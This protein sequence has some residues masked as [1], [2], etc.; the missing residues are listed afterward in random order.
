M[1]TERQYLEDTYQFSC[2]AKIQATHQDSEGSYMLLDKTIFYPQGG[3]QPSDQGTIIAGGLIIPIQKVKHVENEIKHYTDR[4]Y[5]HLVGQNVECAISKETRLL[6]SKLHTAGHLISHI[7]EKLHPNWSAQKGHHFPKEC[8]IEFIS[9]AE[10][11][12]ACAF[13]EINQ[14]IKQCIYKNYSIETLDTS[15]DE[16]SKFCPN[17]DFAIPNTPSIRLMRIEGFPYQ[18]CGGTHIKGLEELAGL[19]IIKFKRKGKTLKVHY[20]IKSD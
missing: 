14:E 12:E 10:D 17:I 20:E 9:K 18:P 16:F 8:Y 4:S 13:E 15:K 1:Q 19:E 11:L 7:V 6:H 2:P 5:S 3:G